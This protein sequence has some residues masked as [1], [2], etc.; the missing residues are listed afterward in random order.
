MKKKL[1]WSSLREATYLE[2]QQVGRVD[3]RMQLQGLWQEGINSNCNR[4]CQNPFTQMTPE[5]EKGM[6]DI[7]INKKVSN[8]DEK[9][10][11]N[12]EQHIQAMSCGTVM[13]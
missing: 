6:K 2:V 12:E 10:R 1:T 4:H 7:P 8:Y 3:Q 9:G 5:E 11:A 13:V